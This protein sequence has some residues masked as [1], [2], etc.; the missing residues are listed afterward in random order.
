MVNTIEVSP[1]CTQ[2]ITWGSMKFATKLSSIVRVLLSCVLSGDKSFEFALQERTKCSYWYCNLVCSWG[3]SKILHASQ[4]GL[5]WLESSTR[6]QC[7]LRLRSCS[8]ISSLQCQN[9]SS[10]S[11][12]RRVSSVWLFAKHYNYHRHWNLPL[13]QLFQPFSIDMAQRATISFELA[14]NSG[15][16]VSTTLKRIPKVGSASVQSHRESTTLLPAVL[17]SP[18]LSAFVDPGHDE[19]QSRGELK[20]HLEERRKVAKVWEE[21]H[22]RR[23]FGWRLFSEERS[24]P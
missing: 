19:E 2:D 4:P 20:H 5:V 13:N 8:A 14:T 21:A 18:F 1:G 9:S 24:S 10:S 22:P 23:M 6:P 17:R 3:V 15:C 16:D 12:F 7:V 11:I